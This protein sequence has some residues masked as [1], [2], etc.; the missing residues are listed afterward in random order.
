[1]F[2]VIEDRFG[3]IKTPNFERGDI[4]YEENVVYL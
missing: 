4:K 2:I 1:M 3:I